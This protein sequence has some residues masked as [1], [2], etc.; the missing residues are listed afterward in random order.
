MKIKKQTILL[1]IIGL[2]LISHAYT[3]QNRLFW[4]G[5]DWRRADQISDYNLEISYPIKA[6]Y[7]NGVKDGRLYDYL[8]TWAEQQAFADSLF[9][10]TDDYLTTRELVTALDHF[11]KDPTHTYIPVVSAILI[12][13]MY[14]EQIPIDVIES[15]IT[16]TKFWINQLML[17]LEKDASNILDEKVKKHNQKKQ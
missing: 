5:G 2:I 16:E 17:D 12:V 9:A 14:G 7:V 4:D 13:N 3:Q 11:Y 6:A 10:E 8:K 15:Y 1:P